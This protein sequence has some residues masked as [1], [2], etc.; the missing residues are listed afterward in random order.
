L[1]SFNAAVYTAAA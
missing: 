1:K